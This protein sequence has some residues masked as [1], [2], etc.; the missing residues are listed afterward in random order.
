MGLP[1][2]FGVRLPRLRPIWRKVAVGG[3]TE[4]ARYVQIAMGSGAELSYD[5]LLAKD[6]GFVHSTQYESLSSNVDEIMR[7]LSAL[8]GK[9]R[10]AR[11]A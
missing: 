8:S 11:A 3:P 5:F 4:R 1:A 10:N 2:R 9:L 7:M 6:L